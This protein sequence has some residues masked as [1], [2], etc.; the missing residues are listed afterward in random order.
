MFKH[1]IGKVYLLSAPPKE[2]NNELAL[3]I[4]ESLVGEIDEIE[5]NNIL[6]PEQISAIIRYKEEMYS[7]LG[8]ETF[9]KLLKEGAFKS[10]DYF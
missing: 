10:N 8:H 5:Y 6:T 7:I 2:E 1:F 9:N 3:T 4:P